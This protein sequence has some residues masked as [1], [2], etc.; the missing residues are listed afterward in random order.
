MRKRGIVMVTTRGPKDPIIWSDVMRSITGALSSSGSKERPTDR[1]TD[2]Q[3]G[4]QTDRP[5]DRT[6]ERAPKTPTEEE[7]AQEYVELYNWRPQ[8]RVGHTEGQAAALSHGPL[9]QIGD[10]HS[11]N[12]AGGHSQVHLSHADRSRHSPIGPCSSNHQPGGLESLCGVL[13]LRV[14]LTQGCSRPSP[15]CLSPGGR[16]TAG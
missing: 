2:R 6:T 15:S 11:D 8:G 10:C 14:V 7:R 16:R 13:P 5:T 3:T 1:Q 9:R 4:R 12:R